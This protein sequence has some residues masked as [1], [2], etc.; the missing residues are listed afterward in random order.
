MD[1]VVANWDQVWS[2][3]LNHARLSIAPIVVGFLIAVPLGRLAAGS[4]VA[5]GIILSTGS[6]LYAIPSLPLFLILP[7]ILATRTLDE[8]NLTVALTLYAVAIMVRSSTDAFTSLPPATLS[9]ATAIGFGRAGRF[10][11]VELPLAGPVLLAGLRVISVSTVAMVTVGALI[12]SDNL[13]Y[14][15]TNGRATGNLAAV[16]TGLVGTLLLAAV[17]DA[18][19]QLAGRLAMPWRR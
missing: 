10:V 16:V 2:L 3:T 13:G 17:F 19:L 15:F 14:L 6:L 12:G 18:I 5:R 9:A 1:W 7:L 8:I 4:R 11:R